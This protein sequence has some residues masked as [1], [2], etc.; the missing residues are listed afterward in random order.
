MA[1]D[2]G[3][4]WCRWRFTVS[5]Y[6]S[7]TVTASPSLTVN[8]L[9]FHFWDVFQFLWSVLEKWKKENYGNL[10][11]CTPDPIF[12]PRLQRETSISHTH[13]DVYTFT[14]YIT[15]HDSH[16]LWLWAMWVRQ[17][18][19]TSWCVSRWCR[20]N[21]RDRKKKVRKIKYRRAQQNKIVLYTAIFPFQHV[22]IVPMCVLPPIISIKIPLWL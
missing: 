15:A 9:L 11:L 21:R 7:F 13:F 10:G 1:V 8:I 18:A 3:A 16:P 14:S 19:T 22:K 5:S 12:T 2:I 17:S 4:P 20:T 6:G